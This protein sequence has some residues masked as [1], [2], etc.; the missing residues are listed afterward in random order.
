MEKTGLTALKS[1]NFE[2][3]GIEEC[4][5]NIECRVT[6]SE[7]ANGYGIVVAQIVGASLDKDVFDLSKDKIAERYPL[8]EVLGRDLKIHIGYL[9]D[10][11]QTSPKFP[12]DLKVFPFGR[13]VNYWLYDLTEEGYL[14]GEEWN[15]IRTLCSM[16]NRI[17]FSDLTEEKQDVRKKITQIFTFISWKEWD[18]LHAFM[19]TISLNS[20]Y[21]YNV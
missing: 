18:N 6:Y 4:P 11:V 12:Q 15:Q 17:Y 5:V 14:S 21:H 9:S 8:Y 2:I 3:P 13:N 19:K 10:V 1:K 20:L 7:Q 16:W